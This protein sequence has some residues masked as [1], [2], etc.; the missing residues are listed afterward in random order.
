MYRTTRKKRAE[1]RKFAAM[2]A[3]RVRR[4]IDRDE[5]ESTTL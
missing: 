3:A 1:D 5:P 4:R 2:R